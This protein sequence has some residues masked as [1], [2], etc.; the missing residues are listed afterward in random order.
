[1]KYLS[2][3]ET[4]NP[5]AINIVKQPVAFFLHMLDPKLL[6][7]LEIASAKSSLL[8]QNEGYLAHDHQSL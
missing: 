7:A 8:L 1:V 5:I 4:T 3:V 6:S 2:V